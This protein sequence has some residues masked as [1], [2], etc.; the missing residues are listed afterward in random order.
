VGQGGGGWDRGSI[1]H[2]MKNTIIFLFPLFFSEISRN[3]IKSIGGSFVSITN[4][5]FVKRISF[6]KNAKKL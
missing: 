1:V 5:F 6:K 3:L 4:E 2:F